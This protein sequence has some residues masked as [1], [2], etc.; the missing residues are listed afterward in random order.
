MSARSNVHLFLVEVWVVRVPG[1]EMTFVR[2][3]RGRG[4][5]AFVQLG[6]LV[7]YRHAVWLAATLQH[8]GRLGDAPM[9]CLLAVT[10][11]ELVR[12]AGQTQRRAYGYNTHRDLKN[13]M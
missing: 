4:G 6:L 11:A 10:S 7:T 5:H 9:P 12:H 2:Q 1:K 8:V 3:L 13:T